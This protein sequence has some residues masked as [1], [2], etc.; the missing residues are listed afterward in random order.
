MGYIGRIADYKIKCASLVEPFKP[1]TVFFLKKRKGL[2][3]MQ[4][5]LGIKRRKKERSNLCKNLARLCKLSLVALR[6]ETLR[7]SSLISIPSP[8]ASLNSDSKAKSKHPD[9]AASWW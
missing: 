1:I 4:R 9:P 8:V 2:I 6:L 5:D 7:A 3:S